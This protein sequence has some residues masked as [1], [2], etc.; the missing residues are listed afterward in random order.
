[1]DNVKINLRELLLRAQLVLDNQIPCVLLRQVSQDR[2]EGQTVVNWREAGERTLA[3]AQRQPEQ[4]TSGYSIQDWKAGG[5]NNMI[6]F[7]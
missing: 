7:T 4:C 2:N 1:M 3:K 6:S 5:G